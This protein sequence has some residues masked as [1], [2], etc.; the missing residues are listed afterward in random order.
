MHKVG[1]NDDKYLKNCVC[2]NEM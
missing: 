2:G 1:D